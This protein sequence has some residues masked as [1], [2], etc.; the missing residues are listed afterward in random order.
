VITT[1]WPL[2]LALATFGPVL[3]RG[4][5]PDFV[6]GG[7]AL[8]IISLGM[9]VNVGTGSVQTVLLMAGRSSWLMANKAAALSVNLA[10]NFLL[11]PIYGIAGAA[12]SW[13]IAIMVDNLAALVEVR[14]SL[15]LS[16]LGIGAGVSSAASL[17]TFGLFGLLVRSAAGLTVR[18]LLI[19]AGISSAVYLMLLWTQRRSLD[20]PTLRHIVPARKGAHALAVDQPLARHDST[21]P[22]QDQETGARRSVR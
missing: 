10:L 21:T 7:A 16:P 12:F 5:G 8:A 2:Y 20:L 4:L 22:P 18:G 15:G 14:V 13:T 6:S 11:V 17:A 9:L 1:S 19:Y 3:L